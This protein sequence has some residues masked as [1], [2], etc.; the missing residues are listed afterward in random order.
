MVAAT[1]ACSEVVPALPQATESLIMTDTTSRPSM[2]SGGGQAAAR[3]GARSLRR[4]LRTGQLLW[5]RRQPRRRRR[6][7]RQRCAARRPGSGGGGSGLSGA[8]L[9]GS[10]EE[11][12]V[13][14]GGG[15]GSG[16]EHDGV[17]DQ[18]AGPQAAK[19][20]EARGVQ[21]GAG[22]ADAPARERQEVGWGARRVWRWASPLFCG[23]GGRGR[24]ISNM[25]LLQNRRP[26]GFRK[27][28]SG[29]L[30]GRWIQQM[31]QF[32][33]RVPIAVSASSP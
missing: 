12:P 1:Q 9:G 25:G 13:R 8:P 28:F 20:R 10:C 21:G 32:H 19:A 3:P 31:L 23:C 29:G 11:R 26:R 33:P 5:L 24:L 4:P 14:A 17:A 15:G 16:G 27:R 2:T 7:N 30:A 22:Q 6:R 18:Q